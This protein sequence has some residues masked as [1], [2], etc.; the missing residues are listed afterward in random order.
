MG[1]GGGKDGFVGLERGPEG[2][3]PLRGNEADREEKGPSC[4]VKG[5]SRDA[6]NKNE[7]N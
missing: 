2:E 6:L 1:A 7:I 4:L 3:R 5:Q